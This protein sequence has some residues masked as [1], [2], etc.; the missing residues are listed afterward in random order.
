M[1]SICCLTT[2]IV[3][4]RLPGGQIELLDSRIPFWTQE[5]GIELI[6]NMGISGRERY[7]MINA[8]DMVFPLFYGSLLLSFSRRVR[9]KIIRIAIVGAVVCDW[10]ENI[11]I[12]VALSTFPNVSPAALTYGP[13]FTRLKWL[14]IGGVLLALWTWRKIVFRDAAAA[15]VDRSKRR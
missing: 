11:C 1:G 10:I 5:N 7:L 15:E 12:R 13:I 6:R 9:S 4:K 8:I 14:C 3:L 2:M